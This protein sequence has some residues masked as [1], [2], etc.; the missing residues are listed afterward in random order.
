MKKTLILIL[1]IIS[2]LSGCTK[3]SKVKKAFKDEF[4]SFDIIR[5][6]RKSDGLV[7]WKNI[8]ENVW[9]NENALYY[10]DIEG[11]IGE[12][13]YDELYKYVIKKVE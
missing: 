4:K 7:I 5:L 6:E 2:I 9:D 13:T 8:G 11:N 1:M 3:V 10:C 12:I